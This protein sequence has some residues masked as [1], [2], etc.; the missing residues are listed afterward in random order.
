MIPVRMY[1][2]SLNDSV[3]E[4]DSLYKVHKLHKMVTPG[5]SGI[6]C[7]YVMFFKC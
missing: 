5:N 7:V 4:D 6:C 2:F 1:I 3:M